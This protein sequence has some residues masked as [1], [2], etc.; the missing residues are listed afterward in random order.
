MARLPGW[1][2][3]NDRA[4]DEWLEGRPQAIRDLA[5]QLPPGR[6]YR[7]KTTD[8]RVFLL[9]Y[10]EDGTVTVAVTGQFNCVAFERKV[11]GI[12]PEELEECDLPG[13]DEPLGT[14]ELPNDLVVRLLRGEVAAA[15]VACKDVWEGECVRLGHPSYTVGERGQT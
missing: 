10:S 11:F 12:R 14:L 7:L 6:L 5:A 9:S 4:N 8:H 13:P 3:E 2:E 1:T 15:C